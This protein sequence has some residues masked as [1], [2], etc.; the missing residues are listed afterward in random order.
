ML[1]RLL[2]LVSALLATVLPA[3]PPKVVILSFD[4]LAARAFN[5][6]TMPQV[7]KLSREAWVGEGVP[8]FPSTTFNGHATIAT[9]CWPEHHGIVANSYVDPQEGYVG[10]T[11]VAGELQ[12]EPLWIAAA[13]SG[14][15]AAVYHWP[16][17]TGPWR[18]ESPWRMV[19]FQEGTSDAEALAFCDRALKDGAGLV[20]AYLSGMDDEAHH[21]GPGSPQVLRKLKA[22]D[23]L[24][25]PWIRRIRTQDPEVRI[26][27]CA[28]HGFARVPQWVSLPKV[29]KGLG[30][31]LVAHGGSAYVYL[32]RPEDAEAAL[33][34]LRRAGLQA[35]RRQDLPTRF[36]LAGNPRVGDLVVSAPLGTWLS[37]ARTPEAFAK[38]REGR[39]G[40]HAFDPADRAMHTWLVVF[41]RGSGT[42]GAVP[43]WDLAPT[44]GRLLGLTW[45]QAPD[46][47]DL[48]FLR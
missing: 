33:S 37:E 26:I 21:H 45:E 29:L 28:D 3:A 36:H 17:A 39:V 43:L 47:R 30:T 32:R 11:A 18:G 20:M 4:G 14:V 2:L 48:P 46:G 22:T 19:R 6:R 38:E 10:Y 25:A 1:A 44:V 35:W 23:A 40:C 42:L 12:R 16:C 8:P 15:K 27:L 41:G 24:L 7:W 34:R 13:R 31:R 5:A 9:G